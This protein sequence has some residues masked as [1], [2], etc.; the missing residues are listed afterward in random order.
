MGL[1]WTQEISMVIRY[2]LLTAQKGYEAVVK[3]LLE[4]GAES[5]SKDN[6]LTALP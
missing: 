2:L 1:M 3:L 4:K 6:G 5:D